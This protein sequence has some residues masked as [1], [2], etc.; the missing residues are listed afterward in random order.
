[1][2]CDQWPKS[3]AAWTSTP[4]W[5]AYWTVGQIQPSLPG[6]ASVRVFYYSSGKK[7]TQHRK[8]C[9]WDMYRYVEFRDDGP[10]VLLTIFSMCHASYRW[11]Y[12]RD[13]DTSWAFTA[14]CF[15][16]PATVL[17]W[18]KPNIYWVMGTTLER[19]H[20]RWKRLAQV[21][22][23]R[24]KRLFLTCFQS[25]ECTRLTVSPFLAGSFIRLFTATHFIILPW[26]WQ[27]AQLRVCL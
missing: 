3:T 1:M 27:C 11:R 23:L 14:F 9:E 10:R 20:W 21:G 5:P 12:D 6:V 2:E 4:Q 17:Q 19:L 18:P 22:L 16:R 7:D 26:D 15:K 24:I 8:I 13:K 25:V